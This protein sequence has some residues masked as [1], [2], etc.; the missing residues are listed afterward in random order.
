[1]LT[2][3]VK[4]SKAK[5]TDIRN[6]KGRAAKIRWNKASRA[7]R[8]EVYRADSKNGTYKKIATLKRSAR[9]YTNKKLAKGKRYYYKVRAVRYIA[10]T[11]LYGSF[12]SK[13]SIK[14]RR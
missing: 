11:T 9:S 12:S 4:P 14:V 3:P 2:S 5:V 13:R 8:Y 7:S 6:N 10:G 1:M